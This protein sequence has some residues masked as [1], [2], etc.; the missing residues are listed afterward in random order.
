MTPPKKPDALPRQALRDLARLTDDA[1]RAKYLARHPRLLRKT[2]AAELNEIIRAEL[3]ADAQRALALAEA[4]V[5][6][7]RKTRDRETLGRS[8]RSKANAL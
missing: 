7:A 1:S 6:I 4:A 3:R 8:L 2:I 5:A